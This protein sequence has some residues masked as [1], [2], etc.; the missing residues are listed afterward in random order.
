M[1]NFGGWRI[2]VQDP[3]NIL[4]FFL[5]EYFSWGF[6]VCLGSANEKK[7]WYAT[8]V[9]FIRNRM[10]HRGYHF[11][12]RVKNSIQLK[13]YTIKKNT[14]TFQSIISI[15]WCCIFVSKKVAWRRIC[16]SNDLHVLHMR[17]VRENLET[18]GPSES[19]ILHDLSD[20]SC[21]IASRWVLHHP[22]M[23]R[24]NVV[25]INL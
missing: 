12:F 25:E 21:Q 11:M 15:P 19:H 17:Y 6:S 14:S 16:S 8:K 1:S 7:Y 5:S 24:T 23:G 18:A 3:H 20:V 10:V 13:C 22:C 4:L 2:S 9:T